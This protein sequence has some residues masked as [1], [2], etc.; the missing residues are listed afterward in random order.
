MKKLI[1]ISLTI[2]LLTGCGNKIICKT[3]KDNV[4]ETYTIEYSDNN[5]TK[6]TTQKTYKF[7]SKQEF[8]NFEG[9]MEYIVKLNKNENVESTYKKKF[10]K[11]ILKNIY[12]IEN[13][14]EEDLTKYGLSNNKEDLVNN[15][16]NNGLTCK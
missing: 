10:K 14:S 3:S 4:S 2:F 1:A 15:L 11:Y 9:I 16:K 7:D 6:V 12:T 5:V 13:M 8:K